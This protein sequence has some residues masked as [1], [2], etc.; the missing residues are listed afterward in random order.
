M[1]IPNPNLN[2]SNL[3]GP[4]GCE[5]S[6]PNLRPRLTC[7]WCSTAWSQV[8]KPCKHL[9]ARLRWEAN[10]NAKDCTK[11]EPVNT[12]VNTLQPTGRVYTLSTSSPT[13]FSYS[14]DLILPSDR[15]S[16]NRQIKI[17]KRDGKKV[18]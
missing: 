12:G 17:L 2:P 11:G 16:Y 13:F 15:M 14:G 1:T 4:E 6:A 10:R 5:R 18:I 8:G 9:Y 3:G 7:P